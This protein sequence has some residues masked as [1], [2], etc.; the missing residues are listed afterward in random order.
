MNG[1]LS[2]LS[3]PTCVSGESQGKA[4][5]PAKPLRRQSSTTLSGDPEQD[6]MGASKA[7]VA[8]GLCHSPWLKP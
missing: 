6:F 1:N 8:R 2:A 4:R 3:L 7:A 5:L